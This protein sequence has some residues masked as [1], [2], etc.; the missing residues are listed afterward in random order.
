MLPE[1]LVE[2][3]KVVERLGHEL[4]VA[5]SELARPPSTTPPK[6][7]IGQAH[8]DRLERDIDRFEALHPPVRS[9]VLPRGSTPAAALHL[10]RTV[11]RRAERELVALSQSEEV[12]PLLLAWANRLGDLLFALALAT[13]HALGVAEVAPDYST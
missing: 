8:I 7:E 1:S 6:S 5:Q 2:V 4:F 12:P 3:R 11:A 9:F 13:N 10:A